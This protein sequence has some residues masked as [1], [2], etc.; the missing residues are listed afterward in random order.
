L[1]KQLQQRVKTAREGAKIEYQEGFAPAKPAA[2][3]KSRKS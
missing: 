1:A 2:D 3:T